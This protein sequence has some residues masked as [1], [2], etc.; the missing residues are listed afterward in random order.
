MM[1][2]IR[3]PSG[4]VCV[5]AQDRL[6]GSHRILRTVREMVSGGDEGYLS[7]DSRLLAGWDHVMERVVITELAVRCSQLPGPPM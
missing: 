1:I 7:T 2:A 4:V 3:S 6:E 5:A